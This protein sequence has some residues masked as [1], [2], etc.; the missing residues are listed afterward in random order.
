MAAATKPTAYSYE[1]VSSGS[2]LDGRGL[3]RQADMAADWCD[4]NGYKLDANL[5][6]SDRGRS[7]Y[8]GKHMSHGALGRFL[9]LAQQ[10]DLGSAPVLLIEAVDRLSRQEPMTALQRV[11]FA[12][13]DAGVVI[14]DLED[15]RR[16]D[17][18]SLAGDALVMLVLKAKAAHEYS[19]RLGRRVSA[20]WDQLRDDLRSGTA[21]ARGPAGGKHPFWM[22]LNPTTKEWELNDRAEDVKLIFGEL[23]H[24]GLTITA[25]ALNASGSLSPGGKSWAAYSVRKVATDPAAYGALRLGIYDHETSRAAHHRWLKAMAAAKEQGKRFNEPEPEIPPVELIPN[26]YPAV[27]NQEIFDRVGAA[28]TRRGMDKGARGNRS[29]SAVHTFLQAGIARCQHG[30]TM[31]AMLSKKPGRG[32]IYYLRCR[33][34]SGGKGCR[35]NGKGWRIEVVHSH[36]VTRLGRHLLGEAALPGNDHRSEL[37]GLVARLQA[38][39]QLLAAAAAGLEKATAALTSAVDQDAQLDLLE[40]LSALVEKRRTVHRSA[41]AQVAQLTADINSIKARRNPA[42]EIGGD[43]VRQLLQSLA[44][45]TDTQADRAR[46][47]QVLTRAGLQVVLDDSEPEAL[48]VGMRFGDDAALQWEPLAGQARGV[49]ALLGMVEPGTVLEAEGEGWASVIV[50]QNPL[51]PEELAELLRSLEPGAG[52]WPEV[53]WIGQRRRTLTRPRQAEL[54]TD[55]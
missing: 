40:N 27:V 20:H 15:Q 36:V 50:S 51:S 1:R 46:L 25:K 18:E 3:E 5:D 54:A 32:D 10:G 38:A 23:Q 30:G 19:L 52:R 29:N 16:Y 17:R 26:H 31:G 55:A 44:N 53:A 37:E 24:N 42:D 13:V 33:A 8:K 45:G 9:E 14:I 48:K 11:A 49:A 43:P 22:T 7:A 12:L 34:R 28:L 6:L 2:Q 21:V 41:D 4:R 39:K 47:H 35:C